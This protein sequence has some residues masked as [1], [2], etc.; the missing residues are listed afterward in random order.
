MKRLYILLVVAL[1]LLIQTACKDD[2]DNRVNV[3][4][5]ESDGGQEIVYGT[6][7]DAPG[8]SPIDTNDSITS[9][10]TVQTYETLFVQDPETMEPEPLLAESYETP[11]ENTWVIK[12]RE[13]IEFHDGTPFN[14]EAVKYTFEQLKDPERAAPRSSLLDPVKEIEVEDEYTVILKTDK[15]YGPMLAALSHTNSAIVSPTADKEGDIN[16]EPVGTGPF[17]FEEWVE[18]DHITLKRNE[19]YWRDPATLEKVTYK[20]VPETS[21]AISMLQTGEIDFMANV[22]SDHV[23]RIE[24]LDGVEFKKDVGTRVSYL[25]FNMEKEP[26]SDPDFREAVAYAIDQESYIDQLNGMGVDNES[27]VGPKIIG[28]NEDDQKAAYTYDPEKGKKLIEE[29]G[30]AGEEIT[31]LVAE[32][33]NYV[34]MAEVVQPQLEEI[35]LDVSIEKM[36]W[37]TFLDTTR[38]GNYEMTFMGWANSTAD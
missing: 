18:G 10:V 13:G 23:S 8:L 3:G 15:P 6:T 30:Y 27:I 35:G 25:G 32:R 33:D 9:D 17:V 26:F 7:S 5:G 20:V 37:A 34:K 4:G 2:S 28:Y 24:S 29:N 22:P 36:E 31:L 38:N 14:A 16:K 11:D 21:T 19:D 1:L 12:L